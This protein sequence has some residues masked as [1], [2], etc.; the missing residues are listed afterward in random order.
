MRIKLDENVTVAAKAP[1]TAAGHQ[2]DTVADEGLTGT[3]D[4]ALLDVCRREQRLLITF[5]VGFGDLRV[6]APGSRRHHRAAVARPAAVRRPRRASPA[7]SAT[8]PLVLQQRA[9]D[10][11]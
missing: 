6:P 11:G 8:R 9:G 5:D 3:P 10:R 1:L 7:R 4:P 2:V